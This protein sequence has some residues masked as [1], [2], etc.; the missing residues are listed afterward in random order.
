MTETQF[1][2]LVRTLEA[3]AHAKG[4]DDVLVAKIRYVEDARIL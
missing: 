3:R 2:T 4:S 1:E